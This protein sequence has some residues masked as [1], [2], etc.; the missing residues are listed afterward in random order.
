M[1][2]LPLVTA[3][4]ITGLLEYLDAR[5]GKE[6]IFRIASDTNQ[7]FGRMIN[8]VEAAELRAA[9]DGMLSSLPTK[10]ERILRLRFA[11][12]NS[13]QDDPV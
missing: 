3:G 5:G 7:E 6:E 11:S 12:L 1:E 4:E 13:A 2:P 8:I 10:D 9:V